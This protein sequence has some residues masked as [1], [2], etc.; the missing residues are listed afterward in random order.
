METKD[1]DVNGQV[2]PCPVR[3]TV[4]LAEREIRSWYGFQGG[5]IYED[6]IPVLGTE[7]I[8]SLTGTLTFVLCL[9]SDRLIFQAQ[10]GKR[11]YP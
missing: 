5:G 7:L 11:T 6:G 8:S 3:W 9:L 2:F 4:A 10:A 1:I